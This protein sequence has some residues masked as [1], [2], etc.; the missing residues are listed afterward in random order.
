MNALDQQLHRQFVKSL[1]LFLVSPGY[2]PGRKQHLH[3]ALGFQRLQY[4][5]PLFL[6]AN[7]FQLLAA[8]RCGKM[9]DH[10][11]YLGILIASAGLLIQFPT[12]PRVVACGPNQQ[13]RIFQ[14][15][16]IR[17]QP[18][19]PRFNIGGSVQ[20]IHQQT[21]RALVQRNRHGVDRKI[22][23]P[24]IFLNRRR[25]KNRFPRLRI[26]HPV[27]THQIHSHRPRKA[28]VKRARFLI[29][30]PHLR[31]KPFQVFLQFEGVA[32]HRNLKVAYR[33]AAGQVAHRIS[34]QKENGF[35]LASRFAQLSQSILLVGRQPVFQ[36]ID[37]I[38]HSDSC[39]QLLNTLPSD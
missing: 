37:V 4:L 24:Q 39:F 36:K 18:Q 10:T 17:N 28:K 20:R 31:P 11:F 5:Q 38:R 22:A 12:Q 8:R 25:I 32:M 19:R 33:V 9:L 7:L 6:V 21:I 1:Q 14:K 29:L 27:R 3:P 13:R 26:F 23:P 30:A 2:R 16:I 34:G 15:S 35:S